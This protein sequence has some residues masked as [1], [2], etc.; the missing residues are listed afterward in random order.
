MCVCECVCLFSVLFFRAAVSLTHG[1][2]AWGQASWPGVTAGQ[3]TDTRPSGLGTAR[4][5]AFYFHLVTVRIVFY[6]P[7]LV[8]KAIYQYWNYILSEGT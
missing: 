5:H 4:E 6:F 2:A 7:R 3:A 8:L 1:F